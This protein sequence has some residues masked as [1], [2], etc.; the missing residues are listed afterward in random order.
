MLAF[1]L[2]QL[3]K[4]QVDE[5]RLL[6]QLIDHNPKC[7]AEKFL[8]GLP[9]HFKD[10]RQDF[11]IRMLVQNDMN[12]RILDGKAVGFPFFDNFFFS[13]EYL[14]KRT[15]VRFYFTQTWNFVKEKRLTFC[16]KVCASKW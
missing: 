3:N 13:H 9:L 12:G 6:S 1:E 10:E 11:L 16:K 5:F 15:N 2:N 4:H 8:S 7:V 14:Q